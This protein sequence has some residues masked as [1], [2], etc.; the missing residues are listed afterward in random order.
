MKDQ[1]NVSSNSKISMPIFNLIG[2]IAMVGTVVLMYSSITQKITS[3]ET[4]RELMLNDL[5]KASDQKPIDQEQFLIQES[6]AGDLEKTI[7]RV[8]EMMHNGVNIQRMMKDIDRLRD[9]VEMLKDKVRKMEIVISLLMFLG[10]P[11]VLKE[12]LLMP[13]ISECLKK[14]NSNKK[15]K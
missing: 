6:L 10:E 12:H 8:D 13:S 5:L 11:P 3:L 9:D 14:E 4:S 15:F 7:V 2:I 1:I